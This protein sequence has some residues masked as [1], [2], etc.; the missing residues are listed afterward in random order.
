MRECA[1]NEDAEFAKASILQEYNALLGFGMLHFIVQLSLF[2]L[3]LHFLLYL[4]EYKQIHT[5]RSILSRENA[6][7]QLISMIIVTTNKRIG[8]VM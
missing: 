8:P 1:F 4:T 3:A 2:F 7:L 6:V 5:S